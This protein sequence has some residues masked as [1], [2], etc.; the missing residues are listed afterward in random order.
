MPFIDN[1]NIGIGKFN[2]Y[3][4]FPVTD[5]T[6]H[7]ENGR[8]LIAERLAG[9]LINGGTQAFNENAV[10]EKA[11][12]LIDNALLSVIGSGVLK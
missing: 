6:H 5:G 10:A 9:A 1:Y 3:Q 11:A 8:Q 7:N 2:R 4:Y 12:A